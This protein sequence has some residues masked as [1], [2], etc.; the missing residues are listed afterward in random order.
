MWITGMKGM[1]EATAKYHVLRFIPAPT[2][3][4]SAPSMVSTATTAVASGQRA[5]WTADETFA[6]ETYKS[7]SPEDKDYI[8]VFCAA[9]P[10]GGALIPRARVIAAQGAE[11]SVDCTAWLAAK[12]K[13]E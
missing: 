11:H 8:R 9:N 7:A 2:P 4:I 10:K 6:W 5:A 3:A 12:T 1:K 13:A